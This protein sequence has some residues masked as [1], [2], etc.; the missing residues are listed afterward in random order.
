M[1]DLHSIRGAAI[2]D[3]L[4]ESD[5]QKIGAIGSSLAAEKGEQLF[6][7]A[8]PSNALYIILEGEF[9]LSVM[10]RSAGDEVETAIEALT[11]GDALGW[12]SLVSPH[13]SVYSAYCTARGSVAALDRRDMEN[14]FANDTGLGYRWMRNVSELVG[15]RVRHQQQLW[16]EEVEQSMSRVMFWTQQKVCT[17][18]TQA[19]VS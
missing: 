14:L 2:L 1:V 19:V 18:W 5:L 17:N 12:S 6:V 8:T 4:T 3:G 13:Q 9:A 16:I 7:R 15:R 11:I 10:L